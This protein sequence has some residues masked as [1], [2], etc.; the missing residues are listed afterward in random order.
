M[1][2][3]KTI[4]TWLND[5]HAMELSLVE[6][7]EKRVEQ[8]KDHPD[9]QAKVQEHLEQTKH[10]AE[11]VADAIKR[12]GGDVSDVKAGM[13][14]MMGAMQ[15]TMSD[16]PK[17]KL[18]KNALSDFTAEQFE[19]ASYNAISAAAQVIGDD[20]LASMA[21][22]IIA[23]EESM[24]SFLEDNLPEAVAEVLTQ[25]ESEDDEDK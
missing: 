14:Q 5:A 23:D 2:Q 25:A 3:T 8:A 24:A 15:G 13:S 22:E 21:K 1:S 4:L 16:M 10:H 19:I 11:M 7:L 17:D 12:L 9:M 6:V 18:V 20:E